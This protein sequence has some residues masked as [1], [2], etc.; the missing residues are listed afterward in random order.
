MSTI[1]AWVAQGGDGGAGIRGRGAYMKGTFSVK[2]GQEL[3]ILVGQAG[4]QCS[5]EGGGGG[6]TFVTTM[7]NSTGGGGGG[8]NNPNHGGGGGVSYNGG[9][10]QSNRADVQAAHGKVVITF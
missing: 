1:E 3:K 8:A 10:N 4:N 6:G 2:P 9:T 5:E 7:D